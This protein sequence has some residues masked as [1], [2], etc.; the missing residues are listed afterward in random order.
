[1][2]RIKRNNKGR[3]FKDVGVKLID[4]I[5]YLLGRV[6]VDSILNHIGL[7]L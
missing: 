1:M 7:K 2:N 5:L 3:L 6:I 4:Y